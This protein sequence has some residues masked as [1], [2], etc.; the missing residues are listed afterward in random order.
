SLQAADRL[1]QA[2]EAAREA[3]WL[4]EE[5]LAGAPGNDLYQQRLWWTSDTLLLGL[6]NQG[7]LAE[8][9]AGCRAALQIH[10]NTALARGCLARAMEAEAHA[11]ANDP[12][13]GQRDPGRA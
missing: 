12:D 2:T 10:P 6:E 5:L 7:K 9:V 3:L 8:T 13:T 11:L 1:E 4:H